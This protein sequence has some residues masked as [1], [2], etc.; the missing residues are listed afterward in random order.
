MSEVVSS[1]ECITFSGNLKRV[2]LFSLPMIAN[3]LIGIFPS[4]C[5]MWFL[6]RLGKDQLA[7]AGLASTSFYTVLT[8][9]I[10]GFSAVGIK[11]GHSL[12]QNKKE[13]VSYWVRNG[14]LLAILFSIPAGMILLSLPHVMLWMGQKPHLIAIAT[15]Y[16]Q[17]G[18]LAMIMILLNTA[19]NQYFSGIG[20]PK[21]AFMM[22]IVTLPLIVC[23]SYV[24]VLGKYG[25]H[26]Y[27]L[28]G[29]NLAS[30]VIDSIVFVWALLL[31][32]FAKWSKP[33]QVLSSLKGVSLARCKDLFSLGWPIS[34]QVSGEL[35]ALTV[36][37]YLVG[38]F[39]VSALAAGQVVGQFTLLFV[40][41]TIGLSTAVSILVSQ[42]IGANKMIQ[43]QK[44][45]QAGIF[46]ILLIAVA[47]AGCFLLMPERLIDLY[48]DI[49]H[50]SHGMIVIL[51]IKFME[52]AA[53]YIIFD[54][55]RNVMTSTLRGM[56]DA[57]IPMR[58]GLLSMWVL[59]IPLA[60][61]CGFVYPHGPVALR[62]GFAFA[63]ALGTV[64]L[65]VRYDHQIKK[66][67][68]S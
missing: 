51:G 32:L 38:L 44:T 22:S 53:V 10:T 36:M 5:S 34:L 12:G 64:W 41:T 6:S 31:I 66:R 16:F 47:F 33:Y 45:S 52:V 2:I 37:I 62:C 18:A 49:K 4:L 40:M 58:I 17:F 68:Q 24:L 9:F 29:I 63:I 43:M 39:G 27:G 8:L 61:L 26:T 56:Q 7:A 60:A 55:I 20:H 46:I 28:G 23:L 1:P 57:K 42:S 3:M 19:V 65:W 11:V 14:L 35:L 67:L 25:F 21:I 15:P 48:L 30:F 13:D 59:G 54:G 50:P